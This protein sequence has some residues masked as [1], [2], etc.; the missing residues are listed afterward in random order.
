MQASQVGDGVPVKVLKHLLV[1]LQGVIR[2]MNPQLGVGVYYR[3]ALGVG[4]LVIGPRGGHGARGRASAEVEDRRGLVAQLARESPG[5]GLK[6]RD[7]IVDARVL[8]VV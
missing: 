4:E 7:I 5:R 6:P 3:I 2:G 8:G 1:P